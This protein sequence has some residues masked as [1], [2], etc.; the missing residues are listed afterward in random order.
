VD[1]KRGMDTEK[2]TINLGA[3]DLGKV[4]VLV[5]EGFYSNRTDFIRTAIRNQLTKHEAEMTSTITRKSMTVGAHHFNRAE[6]E[7]HRAAGRTVAVSVV[8]LLSI[9]TDVPPDLAREVF[10][11]VKVRGVFRA[12]KAVKDALSDRTQ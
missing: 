12:D 3:V 7:D 6:L 8:G 2:I 5:D 1:G 10:A 4:D 11:S 9:D